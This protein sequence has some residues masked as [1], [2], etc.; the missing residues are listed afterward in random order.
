[1]KSFLATALMAVWIAFG[2]GTASAEVL[3]ATTVNNTLVSFESANACSILSEVSI[4][5]LQPEEDI[6]G[7][8]FRPSN[9]ELY[10]LGSTSRLYVID[11]VSGVA[12]P[13]GSG[14]FSP[15]LEGESFGFDF[16]PTVDRIRIIS[17]TGQ[18]LRAVPN[19]GT[20]ASGTVAFVDGSLAFAAGDANEGVDPFAV[21]AAY[22]NP[23][24]DPTTGT[25]LFNIDSA[26]DVLVSQNPPNAGTL[27]SIGS[28]GVN[29]ND[30]AGFDI[31]VTNMGYAALLES[32]K[33]RPRGNQCG[34]S[35]LFSVDVTSGAVSRL[36]SIGTRQPIR[37]LAAYIAP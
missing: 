34:T 6:L 7:I 36:G 31:S 30:L 35:T 29:T 8:D 11:L 37:G 12:T 1:M 16:N 20:A 9:G 5:G 23:D 25:T 2:S 13:V 28:L 17:N 32:G 4:S 22:T 18:N 26:L 19:I 10:A 15:A 27:N 21:A 14:P 24:R 3:Y 33:T